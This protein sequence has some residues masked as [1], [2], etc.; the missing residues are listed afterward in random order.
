[1]IAY[2]APMT[3]DQLTGAI[4]AFEILEFAAIGAVLLALGLTARSWGVIR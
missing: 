1:M 3:Y 2:G 4:E